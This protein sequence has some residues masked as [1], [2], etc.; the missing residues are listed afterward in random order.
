MTSPHPRLFGHTAIRLSTVAVTL[1]VTL[2]TV[3]F[4]S[5]DLSQAVAAT[6]STGKSGTATAIV[7]VSTTVKGG[8]TG[9][10]KPG[11]AVKTTGPQV[12]AA[13]PVG[14]NTVLVEGGI[15]L[16]CVKNGSRFVWQRA[17]TVPGGT[18]TFP[19]STTTVV[20][21]IGSLPA[22]GSPAAGP[23]PSIA[24]PASDPVGAWTIS[25]GSVVGYR[26]QEQLLGGAFAGTKTA[27]GRSELLSGTLRIDK[28]KTSL[29]ATVSVRVNMT[30]LK[31]D[32][33]KRDQVLKT[34]GISTDQYPE[35]FFT[36]PIAVPPGADAGKD[37][38]LP[39][40]GEM[41][42]RGVTQPVTVNITGRFE[43]GR[44]L[45]V[46]NGPISLAAFGIT[47]PDVA[48]VV[49]VADKGEIEFSLI[50]VKA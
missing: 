18:G 48:G 43:L 9:T 21:P 41:V 6:K 44:I 35:A 37:F 45:L 8:K 23:S 31:S 30:Q 1:A 24:I 36:A 17:E 5:A 38:A 33:P 11:K 29:T 34:E 25:P 2:A 26:I 46:G 7:P 22:A 14:G 39:V 28:V 16:A 32:S 49:D 42:I 10:T 12:G 4:V 15:R 19:S 47:A 40:K 27:V 50:F 3:C 20:G 13:C